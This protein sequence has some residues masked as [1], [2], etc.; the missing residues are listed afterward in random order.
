M[1]RKAQ[2]LLELALFSALMLMV[3][4]AALSY[5]RN[6]REQRATDESVFSKAVALARDHTFTEKDIDGETWNCSG[7]I[8]SYSLNTD[9]QANR[10][11]QGGQRRTS[12][13]SA[14][15]YYSNAEDPPNLEFNYYNSTDISSG[16]L[17][18]KIYVDRPGG[19]E[20]PEDGL[21][22]SA[23]DWIS[24]LYPAVS[25]SGL[26]KGFFNLIE[27][28]W[29][30]DW[31]SYLDIG[32]RA[33]S[34]GY[35]TYNYLA[36]L[37]KMDE[38]EAER[39]KLKALDE[40]MGEWGWRICDEVHDGK[41]LAG[42]KYVKDVTAQAYDIETDENKSI[43]YGEIQE[44][45]KSNRTVNVGHIVQRKIFRRYDVTTPDPTIPLASHTFEK[46][47]EKGVSVDLSGGQSETWN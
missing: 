31:G 20:D 42:K 45:D 2:A 37:A 10:L 22:L 41:E 38:S 43:N 17:P 15:I 26:V 40:Q 29:W 8:V 33:A 28:H 34:F 7:A 25:D 39:E 23:A 11:F 3:L 46:L 18:K 47:G 19:S 36:A 6:L 16:E 27:E 24:T 14:S 4:L 5:Q 32:L 30:E 12:A 13:S 35:L 21:K 9:R 44:T 1:G